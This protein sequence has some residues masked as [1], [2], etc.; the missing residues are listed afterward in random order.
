[1]LPYDSLTRFQSKMIKN[2]VIMCYSGPLFLN[3]AFLSPFWQFA[4][5]FPAMIEILTFYVSFNNWHHSF[6]FWLVC[7]LDVCFSCM[8]GSNTLGPNLFFCP[9]FLSGVASR[10]PIV[11]MSWISKHH[12]LIDTI[13]G[14][15]REEPRLWRTNSPPL[16]VERW[17]VSVYG[18]APNAFH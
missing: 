18:L 14:A 3:T 16:Q 7:C 12:I 8:F 17:V 2:N 4:L 13:L 10:L 9:I 15:T 5:S 6:Y 11:R 1:M